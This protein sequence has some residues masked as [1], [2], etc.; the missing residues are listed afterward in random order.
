MQRD[1]QP[2]IEQYS[3]TVFNTHVFSKYIHIIRDM[4]NTIKSGNDVITQLTDTKHQPNA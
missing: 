1:I 3:R 2:G 4:I